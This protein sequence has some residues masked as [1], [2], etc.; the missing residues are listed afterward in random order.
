[1]PR[2]TGRPLEALFHRHG[3]VLLAVCRRVLGDADEADDVLVEVLL[4]VWTRADRFDAARG[5][6]LTYLITLARSRSIDRRRSLA[7]R[8]PLRSDR[9][10]ELAGRAADTADPLLHTETAELAARAR[11]ALARPGRRPAGRRSSA[12]SSTG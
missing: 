9:S 1:M 3:P 10:A 6:P 5:S 11:A 8:P 2:A 7:S 12:R 4:E